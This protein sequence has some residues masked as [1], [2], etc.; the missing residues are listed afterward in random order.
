MRASR[1]IGREAAATLA[2]A[3]PLIVGQ[4]FAMGTNVIDVMLAGHLGA[5]VLGA[6]AIGASIWSLALMAMVGLM[7]ALPPSIAQLDGAGRRD[8]V[9]PLFRDALLIALVAGVALMLALRWCGPALAASIGTPAALMGDV[10]GFLDAVAFAAPGTALYFACRGFSEGLSVTRTTMLVS[11]LGALLLLPIGYLLM[12]GGFG[13]PGLGARGSGIA[14]AIIFWMEGIAYAAVVRFAPFY[15]GVVWGGHRR[16]DPR[17]IAALLRLGVPMASSVLMEVGLFAGAGLIIGRLGAVTVAG[18]QIALNIA[19][20]AFMVPLGMSTAITVRV[21]NAV[22]RDDRSGVRRAGLTG[23]GLVLATQLCSC[24]VMLS[25]PGLIAALYTNDPAVA[26]VASGLL[27]VAAV[28]QLSDGVQVAANGA[29]RGIKDTRLPMLITAFAYWG[30]GMP[31]AWWLG[32]PYGMGARGVWIGFIAGLTIA[33]VLLLSR[34]VWLT[35]RR[36]RLPAR[37][38]LQS[39][40]ART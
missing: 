19:S 1:T 9:V 29:L 7:T 38:R 16:I 37:E 26:S 34:F 23:V 28:F 10:R 3:T 11:G 39:R 27:F 17:A 12:Y 6:V 5:H 13:L 8:L 15:P 4:L 18:H 22:G 21:G 20:F 30:V 24:V 36:T 2:L 40:P 33:A 25:V 35:R 14:N 32:F 31:V